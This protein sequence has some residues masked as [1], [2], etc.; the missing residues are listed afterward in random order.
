MSVVGA[1]M[2][3]VPAY[4]QVLRRWLPLPVVYQDASPRVAVHYDDRYDPMQNGVASPGVTIVMP[5][6]VTHVRA[7]ASPQ[8]VYA[9]NL[10]LNLHNLIAYTACVRTLLGV[11]RP[12]L[13]ETREPPIWGQACHGWSL[14]IPGSAPQGLL[15]GHNLGDEEIVFWV[16]NNPPHDWRVPDLAHIDEGADL[17]ALAAVLHAVLGT[18]T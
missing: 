11:L 5:A 8:A 7:S 3:L 4:P 1:E 2:L 6:R 16:D 9:S 17:L 18:K 10:R 14:S 15:S 13:A 12:E